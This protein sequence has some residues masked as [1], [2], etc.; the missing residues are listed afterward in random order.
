MGKRWQCRKG[1]AELTDNVK[2]DDPIKKTADGNV[3]LDYE[4]THFRENATSHK[5]GRVEISYISFI[6]GVKATCFLR[7]ALEG[8]MQRTAM[9]RVRPVPSMR[10]GGPRVGTCPCSLPITLLPIHPE[11]A[12]S[13]ARGAQHPR[14]MFAMAVLAQ[15]LDRLDMLHPCNLAATKS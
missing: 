11:I 14:R 10:V 9:R 6:L 15:T 12:N 3:Y 13:T 5:L 2:S 1:P 4:I 7:R 8:S